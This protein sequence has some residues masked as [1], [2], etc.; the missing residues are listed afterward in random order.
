MVAK[1]IPLLHFITWMVAKK[2]IS[3]QLRNHIKDYDKKIELAR[4]HVGK[5]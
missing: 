1:K 3:H 4:Q 5:E 2:N